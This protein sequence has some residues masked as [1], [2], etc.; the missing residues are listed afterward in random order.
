MFGNLR[1]VRNLQNLDNLQNLENL[2]NLEDIQNLGILQIL[3]L[4]DGTIKVLVEGLQRGR[5]INFCDND[6]FYQVEVE[7]VSGSE[8]ALGSAK[9]PFWKRLAKNF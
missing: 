9:Q 5:I 7:Y 3:K 2:P 8:E 6:D 4:T 1:N